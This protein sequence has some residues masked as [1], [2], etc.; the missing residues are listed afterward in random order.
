MSAKKKVS[1]RRRC[2]RSIAIIAVSACVFSAIGTG[3]QAFSSASAAE[4][5]SAAAGAYGGDSASALEEA[6]LFGLFGAATGAT[7]NAGIQRDAFA[8]LPEGFEQECFS[9]SDCSDV[10]AAENGRIV[11]LL[12]DGDARDA[13]SHVDEAMEHAGWMRVGGEVE[14][15]VVAYSKSSGSLRWVNITFTPVDDATSIVLVFDE[16]G[17]G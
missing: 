15:L 4:F 6:R 2:C 13:A 8:K 5:A 17:K 10:R 16:R 12:Q 11:G 3:V 9:V 1:Q 14:S 7:A